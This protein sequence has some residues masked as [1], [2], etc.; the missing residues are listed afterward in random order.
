MTLKKLSDEAGRQIATIGATGGILIEDIG[1]E[2]GQGLSLGSGI[3]PKEIKDGWLE[4]GL[5]ATYEM[6]TAAGQIAKAKQ[7]LTLSLQQT[8]V[9]NQPTPGAQQ[10]EMDL[11]IMI[12][13][14]NGIIDTSSATELAPKE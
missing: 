7:K 10:P 5:E 12:Q 14:D 13:I 6:D 9:I 2:D 11:E 3:Q 4:V 1:G 8:M